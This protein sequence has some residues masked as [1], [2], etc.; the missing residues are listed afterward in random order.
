MRRHEKENLVAINGALLCSIR[1][2]FNTGASHN[3]QSVNPMAVAK[4]RALV[5]IYRPSRFLARKKK[6]QKRSP[7]PIWSP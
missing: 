4:E 2:G 1:H 7:M 5:E 6:S 3:I